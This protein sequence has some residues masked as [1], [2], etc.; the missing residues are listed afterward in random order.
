MLWDEADDPYWE[1]VWDEALGFGVPLRSKQPVSRYVVCYDVVSNRRRTRVAECL[2]SWGTRVQKSVFE[3][4]LEKRH[5]TMMTR[6]V[7]ALI[8][9]K[10]DRIS[11]YPVCAACD[12]RRVDLGTAEEK[13]TYKAFLIL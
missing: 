8:D 3:V 1:D 12:S 11:I 2:E 10:T 9:P 6:Q 4:V 7:A 5:M 13:P